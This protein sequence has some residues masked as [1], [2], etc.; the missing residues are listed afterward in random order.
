MTS[1][2][3]LRDCMKV[4]LHYYKYVGKSLSAHTIENYIAKANAVTFL[5]IYSYADSVYTHIMPA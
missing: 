4:L 3:L 2:A 1:I 5:R